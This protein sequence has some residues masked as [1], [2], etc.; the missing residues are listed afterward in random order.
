MELKPQVSLETLTKHTHR[1]KTE[2]IGE[3]ELVMKMQ[4]DEVRWRCIQ[5][6]VAAQSRVRKGGMGWG[7]LGGGFSWYYE[8]LVIRQTYFMS[9]DGERLRTTEISLSLVP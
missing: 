4:D 8:G 3:E 9:G 6:S 7:R 1:W 2:E 5:S